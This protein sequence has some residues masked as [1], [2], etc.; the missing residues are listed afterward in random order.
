MRRRALPGGAHALPA[1]IAALTEPAT[2]G[3][4]R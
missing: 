3:G 2:I 4:A 1:L